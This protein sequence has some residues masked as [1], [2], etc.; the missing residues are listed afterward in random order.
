MSA[1][2]GRWTASLESP[3]LV[4]AA[5]KRTQTDIEIGTVSEPLELLCRSLDRQ[6]D[7]PALPRRAAR[8]RIVDAL[9]RRACLL[10]GAPPPPAAEPLVV[11]GAPGSPRAARLRGALLEATPSLTRL[12]PPTDPD[13]LEPL[14]AAPLFELDWHVP[15]YAEWLLTAD[16][17]PTYRDLLRVSSRIAG[18]ETRALL[19]ESMHLEQLSALRAE[20]PGAMV[21]RV[22]DDPDVED[23]SAVAAAIAAR[24]SA[25]G[26]ADAT[27]ISRYW[28]WR[29]KEWRARSSDV[30][31]ELTIPAKRIE[32]DIVGAVADVSAA[33]GLCKAD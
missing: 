21:V 9:V 33:A 25:T 29:M 32:H 10:A 26:R 11:V 5:T 13:S 3:A 2:L 15:A 12:G 18:T 14:I 4:V 16:L 23:R 27:A 24:E 17:R 28:T 19:G 30:E 22:V 31:V 20:M 1:G 6:A 8:R 7:L